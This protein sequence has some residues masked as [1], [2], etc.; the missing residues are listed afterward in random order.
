MASSENPSTCGN[1]KSL[2]EKYNSGFH[3]SD[4][5][6]CPGRNTI[7][8]GVYPVRITLKINDAIFELTGFRSLFLRIPHIGEAWIA[9]GESSF[10]RWSSLPEFQRG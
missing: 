8:Q 10:D 5:S 4:D 7:N 1:V 6:G 9:K 2:S 3:D